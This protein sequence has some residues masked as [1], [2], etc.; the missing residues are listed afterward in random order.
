MSAYS[1]IR[2]HEAAPGVV[3][4]TL[5]RPEAANALSTAMGRDLLDLWSRL[6]ADASV[7]AVVLTGEGR[8]FCAGADLKERDGM[9]DTVWADQHKLFEDMIRAQLACPFPVLAAV[10]GAASRDTM[11]WRPGSTGAS[12]GP[13]AATTATATRMPRAI[14]GHLAATMLRQAR[15]RWRCPATSVPSRGSRAGRGA[16]R[17][18]RQSC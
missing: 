4:V 12:Q 14:S 17:P 3:Q 13:K 2:V 18:D 11:L 16:S 7:R 5:N 1:T 8:F 15:P 9:T 6:S 10:N